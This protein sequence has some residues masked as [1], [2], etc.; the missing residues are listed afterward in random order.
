MENNYRDPDLEIDYHDLQTAVARQSSLFGY[1]SELAVE[2]RAARD[3]A[4]NNLDAETARTELDIRRKAAATGEKLT[5]AKVS[6]LI[7]ADPHLAEL[8]TEVV[9]KN[10][11][12]MLREGKVRALEHKRCMIDNAVRMMLSRSNG[13]SLDGVTET[14]SEEEGRNEI[15]RGL[16]RRG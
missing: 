10:K 16:M 11:E 15:R 3:E 7:D 12:M 4:V 8:K 14:W 9:V 13:M 6:A 1:Y 2:A 5:E